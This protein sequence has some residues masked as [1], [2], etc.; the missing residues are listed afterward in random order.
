MHSINSDWVIIN[1][2]VVTDS[3]TIHF[4]LYNYF[5]SELTDNFVFRIIYKQ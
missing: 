2:T 1:P 4:I 5:S 3:G